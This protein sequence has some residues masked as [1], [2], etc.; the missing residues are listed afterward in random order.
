MRQATLQFEAKLQMHFR[1]GITI[2]NILFGE[3]YRRI[4]GRKSRFTAPLASV[5][6]NLNL[7]PYIRRYTSPNENFAGRLFQHPSYKEKK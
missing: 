4:Y 7:R 1:M 5:A 2:L 6:V 3:V